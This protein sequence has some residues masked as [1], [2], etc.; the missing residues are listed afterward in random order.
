[1]SAAVLPS[2]GYSLVGRGSALPPDVRTIGIP[3]FKNVTD[4]PDLE[5]LATREVKNRFIQDGRLDV[6]PVGSADSVLLGVVEAYRLQP[7][8]YDS[9][10]NVTSYLV[11][12]YISVKHQMRDGGRTLSQRTV[13]TNEIYKVTS[14]VAGAEGERLNA[15]KKASATA[16]E[17]ILSLVVES[18]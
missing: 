11:T 6:A 9:Q 5:Q 13:S 8:S 14:S 3:V 15:L 18:F 12:M 10:N 7:M 16:A 4:Q 1:M 2:C 17:S